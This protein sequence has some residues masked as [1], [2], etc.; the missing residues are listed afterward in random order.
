MRAGV[1]ECAITGTL[2]GNAIGLHE[3]TTHV[4]EFA[5]TWGLSFFG[6]NRTAW[7]ALPE[8]LRATLRREIGALEQRV[9]EA[10]EQE[11]GEGLACNAGRSGCVNGRRGSMTVVPASDSDQ[12]LRRQLLTETVLPGWVRRCGP[13]CADAWNH[14]LARGLGVQAPAE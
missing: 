7:N 2:S 5:V 8:P 14:H 11:T 1:V 10:V 4:H 13:D 3:V 12:A 9:W 6:A